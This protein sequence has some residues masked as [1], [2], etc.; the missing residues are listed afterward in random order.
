MMAS[1]SISLGQYS[2]KGRKDINQ[3]FHG[4]FIPQEPL[5]N[6]KGIC[7][8]LA[9]GIS[10]SKVS[11]IASES[12]V[13]SFFADYYCTSEAWTVKTSAQR[14]LN[15]TNSWLH[16][17]T[18]RSEFRFDKDK[19]YVCT[20]SAMILKSASAH[21]FHA[22]DSRIYRIHEK[23][24][25][26]LTKDHRIRVSDEQYYLSRA[27]G[28][29]SQL[30][31]DY[32]NLQIEAGDVFVLMTDG[33]YE[34][35]S[36]QLILSSI[37]EYANDLDFAAKHIADQAFANGSKDNLTIQIVRIDNIAK[38][39]ANDIYHKLT[40]LPFPP[41]LDAR[42][43]FDGY[44]IV[45]Q[46]YASARSHVYLAIDDESGEKVVLK[47]P[48]VDLREDT[49]HLERFLL[50]EWIARRINSAHVLKPASITRK[51]NYFY[52]ATEYIEGQTLT[53][54]MLDHPQPDM[55][56]VRDIV[57]QIAKGL[58]AFHKLEMLHQD[59]RPENIMIDHTGTVKIIDF[60]STRVAGLQELD[61]AV[62]HFH[63]L[64]TAQYTAPEYFLGEYGTP[65]SDQF[66]LAII[67]YQMLS[68]RFPYGAKVAQSRTR[69]AQRKLIYQSVLH[70]DREIPVWV[71]EALRKALHPN[72]LKRYEEISEFIFDLR[73]P[74]QAFLHKTRPPLL[75][76]N[77]VMFWQGVSLVL[78][79]V[80]VVLLFHLSV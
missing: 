55:E 45:R 26:Q 14:V 80:I 35:V 19:G 4:A 76:R 62:K 67:A 39:S 8:A 36:D 77:P 72:P 11:Q 53:Q 73:Q 34:F 49:A 22:G 16:S 30:D 9:D 46:L 43:R 24:L 6:A 66:S 69:A 32:L 54:W 75:E 17:Q 51:R 41:T 52:I 78:A 37:S 63:I 15:A 42:M 12:A 74:N 28:I 18:R 65:R 10:S 64:G 20:F 40:E 61:S 59:L 47:T 58:R 70:E 27:L 60:G 25:E 7:I 44:T 13:S 57:E 31:L 23:A 1:L 2:N 71:D 48:A 38:H 68:G 79:I 3:D 56:T 29:D 33:V 5:L 21:I 50:E